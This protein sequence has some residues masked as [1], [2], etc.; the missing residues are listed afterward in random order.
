VAHLALSWSTVSAKPTP[1]ADLDRAV[2]ELRTGAQELARLGPASRAELVRTCLASVR[3]MMAEWSRLGLAAKRLPA[4][5]A[6]EWLAGPLP[7]VLQLRLLADSL[8]RIAV[9]GRPEFGTGV[10]Q[11]DDGRLEVAVFPASNL[12]RV[13]ARGLSAYVL[14]Q[15]GVDRD[16]ALE[17]QAALYDRSD[18]DPGVALVLGAGNVSSI[19]TTDVLTQVFNEGR[20]CLLKMNPVN[21]W[22]GPLL[23]RA[24]QP[25]VNAGFL[26]VVYGGA[27][28]G[29]YLAAHPGIDWIHVTGSAATH[30]QL[31]WGPPGPDHDRRRSGELPPLIGV[32]I[33][34]EL[35]NI[36]PVAIVPDSYRLEELAFQARSIA[37]MVT[38]NASF[39]CASAKML[40]TANGWKQRG[41]FLDLLMR[42]LADTPTRYAYYPGAQ[43][44]YR[45]LT[46]G[47]EMRSVGDPGTGE[48]PWSLIPELDPAAT[49]DPLF[50]LEP[51]CSVVS[52]VSVGSPD[53]AEFLDSATGFMNDVLWGTLC[54]GIVI[55]PRLE[56]DRAVAAALDRAVTDLRYGNVAINAWPA[57][58]SSIVSLPWGGYDDVTS[59]V[60]QSGSGFV[61]NTLML[62]KIDKG[63]VR[64]GLTARPTPPWF[65]DNPKGGRV[66]PGL[67]DFQVQP[68]WRSL[69]RLIARM[70]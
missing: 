44:R 55:A 65:T 53:P 62:G 6:E 7:T 18:P 32:P 68:S 15:G 58:N 19:P 16:A 60:T 14:L 39:N 38:N 33:S 54:A 46:S 26:R 63:V 9:R 42:F 64:A 4:D 31:L 12:D 23:V 66:A 52:E 43:E 3:P 48:L 5:S 47:R 49:D 28:V 24:L 41:A 37:T 61:R 13:L 59:Q 20:V 11:R 70:T 8:D 69:P 36:T 51:F 57:V 67:V 45:R 35:G 1:Q 50:H 17:A 21:E 56:R 2:A 30:D 34:A 40:V 25:L 27:D 10:R 22:F 29:Q